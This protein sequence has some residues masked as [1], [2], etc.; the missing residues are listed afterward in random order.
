[1]VLNFT[2]LHGINRYEKPAKDKILA[3]LEDKREIYN[4]KRNSY[5]FVDRM[6]A[7]QN[8]WKLIME[9][10]RNDMKELHI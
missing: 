8:M 3:F 4:F 1:M 5:K 2:F 7:L 6:V 9:D 10:R